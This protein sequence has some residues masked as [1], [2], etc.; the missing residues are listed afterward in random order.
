MPRS[1]S[2]HSRKKKQIGYLEGERI[3]QGT[4]ENVSYFPSHSASDRSLSYHRVIGNLGERKK[5]VDGDSLQFAQ[6][7]WLMVGI[8]IK[9]KVEI[10]KSQ[11]YIYISWS[12]TSQ[13]VTLVPFSF[14]SLSGSRVETGSFAEMSTHWLSTFRFSLFAFHIYG[15]IRQK[16]QNLWQK[17]ERFCLNKWSPSSRIAF[18]F[19]LPIQ[20]RSMSGWSVLWSFS[21]RHC[22]ERL[23]GTKTLKQSLVHIIFLLFWPTCFWIGHW[24]ESIEL[25]HR[26]EYVYCWSSTMSFIFVSDGLMQSWGPMAFLVWMY[27]SMIHSLSFLVQLF[28]WWSRIRPSSSQCRQSRPDL[29]QFDDNVTIWNTDM[30]VPHNH[31]TSSCVG[32]DSMAIDMSWTK[33]GN[34]KAKGGFVLLS[35][36]FSWLVGNMISRSWRG[37]N[38]TRSMEG[39]IGRWCRVEVE[40]RMMASWRWREDDNYR[41]ISRSLDYSYWYGIHIVLFISASSTSRFNINV[42]YVVQVNNNK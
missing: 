40:G 17:K 15:L 35:R 1:E 9:C 29:D 12:L 8:P 32:G 42:I 22:L 21:L 2:S 13:H 24:T 7:S 25:H 27:F 33:D 10:R 23:K 26:L 38:E 39:M 4:L 30:E 3:G 18:R 20:T 36:M 31:L 34:I 6:M 14:R 5:G 41:R 16:V 11:W 37:S 19:S 28:S